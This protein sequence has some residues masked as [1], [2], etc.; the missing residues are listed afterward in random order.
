MRLKQRIVRILIREIVAD[1]DAQQ[2]EIVLLIALDRR[3]SFGVA[4]DEE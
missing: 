3:S 4:R 2:Q 1:V